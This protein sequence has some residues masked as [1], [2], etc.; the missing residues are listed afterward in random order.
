MGVEHALASSRLCTD[1]AELL[2]DV[3]ARFED[4]EGTAQFLIFGV[5][6]LCPI[7]G[8]TGKTPIAFPPHLPVARPYCAH[9]T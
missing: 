8:T 6:V 7:P 3:A 9:A 5:P 4:A 2:F 1:G